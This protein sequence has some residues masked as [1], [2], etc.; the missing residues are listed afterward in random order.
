MPKS[1]SYKDIY[2]ERDGWG[3]AEQRTGELYHTG[4]ISGKAIQCACGA[5]PTFEQYVGDSDNTHRRVPATL[6]V[7]ICPHCER[8]APGYGTLDEMLAA[9]NSGERTHDTEMV[10][11]E[12][13]NPDTTAATALSNAVIRIA[14]EEAVELIQKRRKI[15]S[16]LKD[17]KLSDMRREALYTDLKNVRSNLRKLQNFF[18]GSP[19]LFDKDGDAILSGIRKIVFPDLTYKERTEI[20]LVLVKM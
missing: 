15:A 5:Y 7:A 18:E 11:A 8:R 16:E 1:I 4:Y 19:M 20:P 13:T 10:Q 17:Q 14:A 3:Y 12:L 6:F 2:P 9:W